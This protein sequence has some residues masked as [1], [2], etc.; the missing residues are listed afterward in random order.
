MIF[1]GIL[2][3]SIMCVGSILMLPWLVCKIPESYFLHQPLKS[4]VPPSPM[5]SGVRRF[6]KNISGFFLL[7]AGIIML[8]VPGQGL[9]TM[10]I[11][12]MLIDFPGKKWVEKKLISVKSIQNT[13][14]WIRRKK[15]VKEL[16]FPWLTLIQLLDFILKRLFLYRSCANG[17]RLV[18]L[19]F[20]QQPLFQDKLQQ[21]RQ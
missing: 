6:I 10:L 20:L 21:K 1:E 13:L 11:G 7:V 17:V 15:G 3:S 14:N 16:K 4:N 18:L 12:I 2:L 8:F 9:L 5:T 19:C